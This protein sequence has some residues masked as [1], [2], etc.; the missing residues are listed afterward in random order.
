MHF[1]IH[2]DYLKVLTVECEFF[3]L[4]CKCVAE[5]NKLAVEKANE[6][7]TLKKSVG[8][9]HQDEEENLSFLYIL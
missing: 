8:A 9:F 3:T 6:M 1:E 4:L 2:I 7:R 5:T